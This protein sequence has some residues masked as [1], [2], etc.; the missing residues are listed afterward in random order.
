L[1][2]ASPPPLLPHP[3]VLLGTVDLGS[4]IRVVLGGD[5][6]ARVSGAMSQRAWPPSFGAG[7]PLLPQEQPCPLLC[8]RHQGP[9]VPSSLW[10][11][12]RGMS[13]RTASQGHA[14]PGGR[15]PWKRTGGRGRGGDSPPWAAIV[16]EGPADGPFREKLGVFRAVG[17]PGE[18]RVGGD[19]QGQRTGVGGPDKGVCEMS[20]SSRRF[21]EPGRGSGWGCDLPH[22]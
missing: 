15:S 19:N 3:Q 1:S 14:P 18:G 7:K 6:P 8:Q 11:R 16:A 12:K 21:W 9:L 20:G 4:A 17:G 13:D 5:A 10:G 2:P 22:E